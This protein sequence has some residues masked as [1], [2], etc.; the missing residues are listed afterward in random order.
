MRDTGTAFQRES[1]LAAGCGCPR[2]PATPQR[3][4]GNPSAYTRTHLRDS[5]SSST[6]PTAYV[7]LCSHVCTNRMIF[8]ALYGSNGSRLAVASWTRARV[9][10]ESWER[11]MAPRRDP[12]PGGLSLHNTWYV[13]N[14]EC[15]ER[16]RQGCDEFRFFARIP[17]QKIS[18][19]DQLLSRS[20]SPGYERNNALFFCTTHFCNRF[21][22]CTKAILLFLCLS[23]KQP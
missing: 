17:L 1:L 11:R 3:A 23:L 14:F 19:L 15:Y 2:P 10:R 12:R 4:A 5:P 7:T 22:V 21:V 18:R 9:S 8:T 6:A 20:S 16:L 13:L